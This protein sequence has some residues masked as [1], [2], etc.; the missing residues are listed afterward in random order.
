MNNVSP[1]EVNNHFQT[2]Q[3]VFV[4]AV[5]AEGAITLAKMPYF[6]PS[7]ASVFVKPIIPAFAAEYCNSNNN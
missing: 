6:A 3:M 7:I 2:N 4:I 5:P 1:M